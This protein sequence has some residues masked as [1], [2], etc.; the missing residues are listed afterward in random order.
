MKASHCNTRGFH[1]TVTDQSNMLPLMQRN[2]ILNNLSAHLID[3]KVLDWGSESDFVKQPEVLLAADCVYFEPAFPLLL[4]TL[5][6]LI[7][8][9]TTCY[10]CFKKRR[11]ADVKFVKE[12]RRC[13]VFED[14]EDDPDRQ[15]W[16]KQGIFL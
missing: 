16:S 11:H 2:L 6:D 8:P 12:A 14:I 5:I 9:E 3:V 15:I 10:F 4:R 1:M 7:G 13:F